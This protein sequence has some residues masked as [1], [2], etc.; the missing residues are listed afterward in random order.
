MIHP[1]DKVPILNPPCGKRSSVIDIAFM[2][3]YVSMYF[4]SLQASVCSC[5]RNTYMSKLIER[6][7]EQDS[8][9]EVWAHNI[10]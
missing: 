9:A 8:R 2:Y 3:Y 4:I 5:V 7:L 1:Q 6:S 10:R